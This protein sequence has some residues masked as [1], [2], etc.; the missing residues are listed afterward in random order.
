MHLN[1]H[2]N[3]TIEVDDAQPCYAHVKGP[4]FLPL[5]KLKENGFITKYFSELVVMI[6]FLGNLK[7][8]GGFHSNPISELIDLMALS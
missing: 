1:F 3:T 8:N 4:Y 5:F 7:V 6:E 2:I